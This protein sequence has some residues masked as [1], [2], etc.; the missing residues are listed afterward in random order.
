MCGCCLASFVD[1]TFEEDENWKKYREHPGFLFIDARELEG[2]YFRHYCLSTW[3]T[4]HRLSR[5]L[6]LRFNYIYRH[7]LWC[8]NLWSPYTVFYD[9][10]K[11][12]FILTGIGQKYDDEFTAPKDTG[13]ALIGKPPKGRDDLIIYDEC[14]LG[15][16]TDWENFEMRDWRD[17]AFA[18]HMS[19]WKLAQRILGPSIEKNLELF[20]A[21][22]FQNV[23]K[24]A[25]EGKV[26]VPGHIIE[27][28]GIWEKCAYSN[29]GYE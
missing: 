14:D 9:S 21:I 25:Y 13:K 5:C 24:M 1:T 16:W 17:G 7:D 11:E 4:F 10:S 18:V 23:F 22:T 20:A 28:P 19:C 8:I 3:K 2:K 12:E 6:P 29:F 26:F 15:W 27:K